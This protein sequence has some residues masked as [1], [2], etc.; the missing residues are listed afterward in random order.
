MKTNYKYTKTGRVDC[1]WYHPVHGQIPYTLT[2]EEQAAA[3]ADDSIKIAPYV[4]PPKTPQ[5]VISEVDSLIQGLLNE[6]A[7]ELGYDSYTSAGAYTKSVVAKY[8]NESRSLID[9]ASLMY[10]YVE[11]KRDTMT[12]EELASFEPATLLDG[13]TFPD[14]P[15]FTLNDYVT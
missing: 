12:N 8:K 3:E 11:G 6:K 15:A 9:W 1:A 10:S 2:P 13:V 7:H 14:F 5:Q 4:T